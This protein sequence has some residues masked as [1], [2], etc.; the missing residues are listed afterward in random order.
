MRI[1]RVVHA[2]LPG[3]QGIVDGPMQPIE[4]ECVG[5]AGCF[6]KVGS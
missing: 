3:G 1:M 4:P 2:T 6:A 5:V